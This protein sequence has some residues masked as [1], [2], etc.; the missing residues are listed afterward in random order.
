MTE[1]TPWSGL[2]GGMLIGLSSLLMLLLVG[3]IAGISGIA[4]GLLSTRMQDVSWRLLFILGMIGAPLLYS[5]VTN[6]PIGVDVQ[7]GLPMMVAGGFLVGFGT[8]MGCGCTSGHG[9]SGIARLSLGSLVAT[10]VFFLTALATVY[11]VR[12]LAG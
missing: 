7:V 2:L 12:H 4:A 3:R 5:S 11:V 6:Q 8:R 10:F 1:F 9:V